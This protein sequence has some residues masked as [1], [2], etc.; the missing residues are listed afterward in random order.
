M[1]KLIDI[2]HLSNVVRCTNCNSDH[3][4][5]FDEF[6]V[7]GTISFKCHFCKYPIITKYKKPLQLLLT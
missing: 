7:Y 6:D 1:I 3:N 4:I 5:T 2:E